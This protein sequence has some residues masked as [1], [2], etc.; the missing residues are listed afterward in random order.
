M[1]HYLGEARQGESAERRHTKDSRSQ[2]DLRKRMQHVFKR[3]VDADDIENMSLIMEEEI[4]QLMSK[5]RIDSSGSPEGSSSRTAVSI[6]S[7]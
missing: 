2:G 6:L 5:I 1:Q 4:V 7:L 3:G